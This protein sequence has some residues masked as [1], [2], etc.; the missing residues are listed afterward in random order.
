MKK[1]IKNI[2]RVLFILLLIFSI[3]GTINVLAEEIIFKVTNIRV[4][5]KSDSVTVNNVSLS[6]GQLNNDVEFKYKDDYIK[7]SITR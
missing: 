1:I 4:K 3:F 6:N 2:S 7:Y 5:E